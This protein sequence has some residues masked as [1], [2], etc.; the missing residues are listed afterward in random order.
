MY[1]SNFSFL[2]RKQRFLFGEAGLSREHCPQTWAQTWAKGSI[3][4]V[5][6]VFLLQFWLC[7]WIGLDLLV[8]CFG[9][10]VFL[11]FF[12]LVVFWFGF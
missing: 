11:V 12:S 10:G 7:C 3:S 8:F 5:L 1:V 6:S 9:F 4:L 2:G